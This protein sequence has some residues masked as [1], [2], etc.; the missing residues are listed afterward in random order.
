MRPIDGTRHADRGVQPGSLARQFRQGWVCIPDPMKTLPTLAAVL[1]SAFAADL[2]AQD[3]ICPDLYANAGGPGTSGLVWRNTAFRCQVI[4]EADH[5][6]GRG[7]DYPITITRLQWRSNT[8]GTAGQYSQ[9][10]VNL[11]TA[12][13]GIDWSTM[14]TTFATNQGLDNTVVYNG[15]VNVAQGNGLSPGNYV[16]DIILTTPF[17]YNPASGQGLVVEMDAA[18]APTFT[19]T[20]TTLPQMDCS[21]N[22]SQNARARRNSAATSAALTGG[23]SYFAPVMKFDYTEPAGLA[24]KTKYGAGCY[25]RPQSFYELFAPAGFDLA[26]TATTVNSIRLIPNGQGGFVALPG[27]NQWFTPTSPDLLLADDSVSPPQAL[28]FTFNYQFGSTTAIEIGS[29]GLVWMQPGGTTTP[30]ASVAELLSSGTRF[31]ALWCDLNP[32]AVD[33]VTTLPIGGSIHFDV[34][35]S[36]QEV[37]ATWLGVPLWEATQTNTY[38][39]TFQVMLNSSGECEFRYMDCNPALYQTITGFSPGGNVRDPGSIDISTSM[40]FNTGDGSVAVAV[41]ADA[42]PV[43]GTSI[44]LV[45]SDIPLTAFIGAQ[46]FGLQELNP[47]V[48]LAGLGAPGCSQFTNI[49][50]SQIL[51]LSGTTTS[52]PFVV[53]SAPAFVGVEIKTQS[54]ILVNGVNALGL[55]TSNG[56]KLELGSV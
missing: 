19:G 28:P 38:Q 8:V 33:P 37:Y 31:A 51:F 15:A 42:R 4:Y 50:A 56:L 2:I 21:S 26:G 1:C 48:S 24:R 12:P 22:V 32:A 11:S 3:I 10:Q 29:N 47:G 7:I 25:D 41:D 27:S 13:V 44:N 45:T 34:N 5:W 35:P 49:D 16:V 23:L 17:V 14:S 20:G 9:V 6:T 39:Q 30:G 46:I 55:L 54:A 36:G 52:V 18:L 53:P 43:L 40:P